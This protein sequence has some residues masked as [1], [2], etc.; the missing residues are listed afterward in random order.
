MPTM[1]VE[2]SV[3]ALNDISQP[4]VTCWTNAR[5][6]LIQPECRFASAATV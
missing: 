2:G 6:A 4:A 1:M 3:K 5:L